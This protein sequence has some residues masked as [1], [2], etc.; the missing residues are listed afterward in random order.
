MLT[1]ILNWLYMLFAFFC[2]GYAFS[3][4]SGKMLRYSI[5]RVDGILMAGLIIAAVYA[6]I[7]SLFY[8]V[9]IEA[10]VVL[11]AVCAAVCIA[12]GRQMAGFLKKAWKNCPLVNKMI[13]LLIFLAWAFFTSR[14]YRVTDMDLYHG[15]S[16]R[17]IEEYG[18][19]KGIGNLHCRFGYNSSVFAVSALFSM[20]FLLGRSLHAVNGLIAFLLS[21][22]A[23]DLG[24]CFRRKK[25]LLSDYARVGAVYYLTTIWDEIIAPSS[26]YA[27]MCMIFMIVIKWLT[28]LESEDSQERNHIAPYGLL[29]VACAFTLT[30]KLS[31]GLIL[32]LVLKPA[33]MLLKEKRWKEIS[34]YLLLGL[35]T[36]VPWMARTVF[37]TGWLLYPFPELDLFQVDW[38]MTDL[39][40]IESDA[41]LIKTYAR[42]AREM[43]VEVG[44]EEWF[45]HWFQN[46]L[47]STEKLLILADAASCVTVIVSAAVIVMKKKWQKLDLLLVVGTVGCSYVFWQF[48]APMMRY[49]YAHV[50]LLAALVWGYMIEKIKPAKIVYV[51]LILYGGYKLYLGCDYIAGCCLLPNYIWQET[52]DSYECDSYEVD[53]V[54]IYYSGGLTGYDPFP[55]IPVPEYG[56]ELRGEGLKD[57]FRLKQNAGIKSD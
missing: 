32:L 9:G 57:G 10:N 4:F 24:K 44:I 55:A 15:Q 56:V 19:V 16:I 11:L 13:L 50:L 40:V 28:Q 53:G 54:T 29:C 31:A 38:K 51:F 35:L 25:M 17:W 30:L 27:V 36:A 21:M 47:W 43:G 2:L 45:P 22:A 49:G 52:Y 14:G 5:R 20:K 41:A 8:R 1:V 26:D 7:F 48:S 33:Y 12:L 18:V 46:E 6:Q 39:S 3:K 42:G 34:I 37:I 23:L